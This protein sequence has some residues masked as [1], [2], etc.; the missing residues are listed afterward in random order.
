MANAIVSKEISENIVALSEVPIIGSM[1]AQMAIDPKVADDFDFT[2]FEFMQ[3][4]NAQY[5]AQDDEQ[6]KVDPLTL[7]AVAEA[8]AIRFKALR[9][10]LNETNEKYGPKA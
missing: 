3:A 1:A 10:Y 2:T 4:A 6:R 9:N 5:R 7:G 8:L